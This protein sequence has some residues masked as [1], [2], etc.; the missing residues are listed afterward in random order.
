MPRWI[1][2]WCPPAPLGAGLARGELS[3][4]EFQS[5]GEG[6]SFSRD[7]AL[8]LLDLGL[9]GCALMMDAQLEAVSRA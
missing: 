9:T 5:T 1:A 8:A 2:I 4:V 6:R 7:E 3:V